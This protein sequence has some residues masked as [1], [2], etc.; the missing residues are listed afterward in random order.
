M[1]CKFCGADNKPE[2]ERCFSCNAPL[3]KRSNLSETDR[4]GLENYVK[5]VENMLKTAKKKAD[6]KTFLVFFLLSL[7]WMASSFLM[8]RVFGSTDLTMVVIF[9]VVFGLVL[10]IVFGASIT[11][12]ENRAMEKVFNQKI[13]ADIREYLKEMSYTPADFQNIAGETLEEKSPLNNFLADI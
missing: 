3:P 10:F 2:Q 9:A 13:K 6:G 12:F 4:K 8:Y 5:S 1:K 7:V 11:I